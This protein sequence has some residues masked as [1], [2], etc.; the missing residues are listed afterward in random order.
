MSK[1]KTFKGQLPIGEQKKL[2]LS[3]NDGLTGY[4][5]KK[6]QLM[7]G[8]PGSQMV[9]LV[10]QIFLTDQTGSITTAVN[11]NDPD[12]L[13]VAYYE[14]NVAS[15]GVLEGLSNVVIFDNETFNQ[16]IF[17]NITDATGGTNPANYYI[18]LEQFKI[19]IN[20]ATYHTLKNIRSNQQL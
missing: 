2:L 14:D 7:P 3:T 20:T 10:G 12:L 15:G 11:F 16:D 6:F 4:K 5:I 8:Q 18:E 9:E 13:A 17:V 1:I 19:D